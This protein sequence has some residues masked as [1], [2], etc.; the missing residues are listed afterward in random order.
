MSDLLPFNCDNY[1]KS[2]QVVWYTRFPTHTMQSLLKRLCLTLVRR[3]FKT[4][5]IP[6][7]WKISTEKAFW[8][9][10]K[11]LESCKILNQN[12]EKSWGE[13]CK[14]LEG[15]LL[16]LLRILRQSRSSKILNMTLNKK[17]SWQDFQ[18]VDTLIK[19]WL[20]S[21]IIIIITM[22]LLVYSNYYSK[23]PSHPFSFL[24]PSFVS[25]VSFLFLL[26]VFLPL[27]EKDKIT[28]TS[29]WMLQDYT[30]QH[31]KEKSLMNDG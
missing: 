23:L 22:L 12:L 19:I 16:D 11:Q 17:L 18:L 3:F 7:N 21:I 20:V 5:N 27:F 13:S 9:N 6:L 24:L 10:F 30:L 29:H 25:V 4:C 26:F 31:R 2:H 14:I 8:K 15:I 1:F 28:F